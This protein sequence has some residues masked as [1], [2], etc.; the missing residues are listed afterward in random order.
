M[1][2]V[3]CLFI[4]LFCFCGQKMLAQDSL[5]TLEKVRVIG[6]T[7]EIYHVLESN[8]NKW[9]G[10]MT[11]TS[12]GA[13]VIEGN[14]NMDYMD[15]EWK[16]Y[17][18]NG[19]LQACMLYSMGHFVKV[20]EAYYP[21]RK[22]YCTTIVQGQKEIQRYFTE[23]TQTERENIYFNGFWVRSNTYYPESGKLRIVSMRSAADSSVTETSHYFQNEQ[24]SSLVFNK[25]NL[26]YNL[27]GSYDYNGKSR[28][29][30]D[31][32]DG[33]GT[34][35]T[36]QDSAVQ[37][38]ASRISYK[39]GKRAGKATYYFLNGKT[40]KTGVFKDD[41]ESGIWSY[42]EENGKLSFEWDFEKNPILTKEEP[43]LKTRPINLVLESQP[44]FPG[45]LTALMGFLKNNIHYPEYE[46]DRG[47][48]GTVFLSFLVGT[49]G[50]I[51]QIKVL[52]SVKGSK[53]LENESI[54]VVKAMPRWKPGIM[55]GRVVKVQFNLP[56]TF[57]FR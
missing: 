39:D 32:K 47:I 1:K 33:N 31:L 36:Y 17:Y 34:L 5:K 4:I 13:L 2:I 49:N 46:K 24:L 44:G 41:K 20:R 8:I 35:I 3:Q 23:T 57:R 11:Y 22:P 25:A 16:Y 56:V 10:K 38:I 29:Q 19:N 6:S 12:Q 42:Y 40:L 53:D 52:R 55:N 30:G 14:Y 50:M 9:Y 45:G 37:I 21:D 27:G 15:G 26:V 28:E 48:Q 43:K 51:D 7:Q 18:S 54:R